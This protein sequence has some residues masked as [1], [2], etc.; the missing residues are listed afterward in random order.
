MP[1]TSA[2]GPTRH[3]VGGM[4]DLRD[5]PDAS[6]GAD[7][8]FTPDDSVET[9]WVKSYQGEVLGE[10]FFAG[11]AGHLGDA[12]RAAKMRV[13]STMELRTREAMIPSMERAG[14]STAPDPD[15]VIAGQALADAVA[16]VSWPDLMGSFEPVTKQYAAMYARIGQLDPAEQATSDLLVAHELALS[17]FGRHELAGQADDALAAILAV[18]HMR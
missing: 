3:S 1:A 6:P 2:P 17:E 15:S 7:A 16:S 5:Q 12:D 4:T 13:L 18:P 14:L 10:A 9:L 11:I 8:L